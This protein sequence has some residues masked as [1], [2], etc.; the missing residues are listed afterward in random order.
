MTNEENVKW[1][2]KV[3][4]KGSFQT[5]FV[6]G[7]LLKRTLEYINYNMLFSKQIELHH[8]MLTPNYYFFLLSMHLAEARH[9]DICIRESDNSTC[10]LESE[11]APQTS[12]RKA[13]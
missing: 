2:L 5:R 1:A 3:I 11:P 7:M 6:R 4:L 10:C 8:I 9:H 12:L 13:I